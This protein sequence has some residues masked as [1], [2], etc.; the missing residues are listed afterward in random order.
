MNDVH[1]EHLA[2]RVCLITSLFDCPNN[3]ETSLSIP[4]DDAID[5]YVIGEGNAVLDER[6]EIKYGA[7]DLDARIFIGFSETKG[8][9]SDE[10]FFVLNPHAINPSLDGG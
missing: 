8:T 10:F 6:M 9:A 4:R 7:V 5:M 3:S 1:K 2:G